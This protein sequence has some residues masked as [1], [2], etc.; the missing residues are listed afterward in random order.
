[1]SLL[2]G[3]V[4]AGK[5]LEQL[6]GR[7]WSAIAPEERGADYDRLAASYDMVVGNTLYNRLVW[8]NWAQHY[9]DAAAQF[10]ADAPAGPLLDC[11]CG[12]LVFTGKIYRQSAALNKLVLMDRSLGMLRRGAG[13]VADATFL[14][15]DALAM[16]FR[17]EAFAGVMSWGMLHVFG[18]ASPLLS[19]LKAVSAKGAS[20]AISTLVLADRPL[21]NRMLRL[22]HRN[23]EV[24]VPESEDQ[25]CAAF[26]RLF[27][28]T[29]KSLRGNM[30]MLEGRAFD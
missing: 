11:G 19:Q 22:L 17:S 12:S 13:R 26:E 28:I 8:G 9:R 27:Q 25:V 5:A 16:P 14:Q 6:D 4:Q 18:T 20:I 23:G 24:A 2:E 15:A 1:M 21:G 10:L 30:L 29:K 3:V 7:L